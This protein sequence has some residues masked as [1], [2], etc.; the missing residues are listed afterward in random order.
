MGVSSWEYHS[1]TQPDSEAQLV[2][3]A[4]SR[5]RFVDSIDLMMRAFVAPNMPSNATRW[6]NGDTVRK[7]E[8]PGQHLGQMRSRTLKQINIW[9]NG[10]TRI[11]IHLKLN[12]AGKNNSSQTQ[13]TN[14]LFSNIDMLSALLAF[15]VR[16]TTE[17]CEGWKARNRPH[18]RAGCAFENRRL[19][20]K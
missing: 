5:T 9:A 18:G 20:W 13:T 14:S 12:T 15:A 16:A 4:R 17:R 6:V 2:L 11:T 3:G 10:Y 1:S 8:Q 19:S 7:S